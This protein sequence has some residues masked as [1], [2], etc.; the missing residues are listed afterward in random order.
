MKNVRLAMS[1][2]L[3]TACVVLV[4]CSDS[5][6][7]APTSPASAASAD[8]LGGLLGTVVQTVD[9]TLTGTG[10]IACSPMSAATTTKVIGPGGGTIKVGPHTLVIPAGA[11]SSPV[12]ITAS[13][14]SEK[15]NRVHFEPDGLQFAKAAPLT[16]SYANCSILTGVLPGIAYI[17]NNQKIL[18]QL[19]S[20]NNLLGRTVTAGVVHFSDYAIDDSSFS[21]H[22]TWW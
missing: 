8:L 12:E 11:L 22:A 20:I 15:I 16:M 18:E 1:A 14:K 19:L 13:I 9:K 5:S 17:G 3:L 6:P 4:S 2:L 10:L 7:I 21:D